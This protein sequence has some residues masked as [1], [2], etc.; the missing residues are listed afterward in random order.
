[1]RLQVDAEGLHFDPPFAGAAEVFFGERRAWSFATPPEGAAEVTWPRKLRL[2]LDGWAQVRVVAGEEALVDEPVRFTDSDTEI[3]L[4]DD[5]GVGFMIDKWGL[6]QR[7]FEN[8]PG[9][10][11]DL[12]DH[13]LRILEVMRSACGIEGW[14]SFGTL[15]GAARHGGAIGYDSDLDLCYVS[16]QATPAEMTVELWSIARALRAAGMRVFIKSGSF[17]TVQV[18]TLDGAGTGI[19]L[20][21]TFFLDGLFYETATV[22]TPLPRSAVLPLGQ[23]EFEGRTVPAPADV[24]AV[25]EASYG[26]GWRVPDPAFRHQPGEETTARF[27]GWFGHLWRQLRDWR[28]RNLDHAQRGSPSP[29]AAWVADRLPPG[30]RVLDVGAGS[31]VDSRYFASRGF[32]VVASDYALPERE[33]L[34]PGEGLV[35]GPVNLYDLRDVLTRGPLVTRHRGPQVVYA[36]RVVETLAPDGREGLWRLVATMLRRFGGDVYLEGET[37]PPELAAARGPQDGGRIWPLLPAEVAAAAEAA[38]GRVS[39]REG[40]A[41]ARRALS[42]QRPGQ[43]PT[44][45]RMIVHWPDPGTAPEPATEAPA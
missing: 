34:T 27:D 33:L 15:L 24:P 25:L 22:R 9:V 44:Q 2:F 23:I 39:Y 12:A 10:V 21:T 45:W 4:V 3:A 42:G 30:T 11:E 13:A 38:G 7:P 16:E 29:F 40:F 17:L 36:R 1:M 18:T 8:R 14:I 32:D 43:Q 26:P 31:G 6:V 20:Y 35:R 19:D 28:A 41:V 5:D 37:W